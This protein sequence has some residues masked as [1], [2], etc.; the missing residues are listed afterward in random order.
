MLAVE[1]LSLIMVTYHRVPLLERCLRSI[2]LNTPNPFTL[3]IIDNSAGAID[4]TLDKISDPRVRV[5]KNNENLG[6]G[7]AFM[8][9]YREIM[10]ES[11]AELFVSIDPDLLLQAEWSSNMI[12][13]MTS[14]PSIAVLAPVLVASGAD[15]FDRQLAQ[16]RFFMHRKSKGS[17]F[18][19]PGLYRNR[20]IAGPLFLISRRFFESVGGYVQNQLYGNDDGEL[21]RAAHNRGLITAIAT[22]VKALHLSDDDQGYRDWKKRNV[23]GGDDTGYWD[24]SNLAK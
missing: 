4:S 17:G 5:Y 9:K 21:C 3:S 23:K 19:G 14:N 7:R 10:A 1:P 12:R 18:L 11:E 15:N 22:K 20:H 16:G 8:S 13:L 6:K 24:K 2:F